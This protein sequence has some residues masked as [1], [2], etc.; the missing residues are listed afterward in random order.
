MANKLV[1]Y[2]RLPQS[3]SNFLAARN[4]Q[5]A[6]DALSMP[7]F[8]LMTLLGVDI[9][10]VSD[11]LARIS[12]VAS[13]TYQT[14]LSLLEERLINDAS[15]GRLPTFLKGLDA[16]LGGGIP[17]SVLTELVGPS[18]IASFIVVI[19]SGRMIEM[20]RNS[21]PEIFYSEGMAQEVS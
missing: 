6:K 17:F 15:S 5:T 9:E 4:I 16:V 21:F 11:A 10:D 14:A 2:M 7:E 19:R 12:K 8:D 20:G 13:P 1:A 3:I 18:G